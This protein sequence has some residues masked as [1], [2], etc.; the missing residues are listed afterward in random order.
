MMQAKK[1]IAIIGGSGLDRLNDMLQVQEFSTETPFGHHSGPI[2][3][4]TLNQIDCLFIPR[5]HATRRTPPHKINYRANIWALK[6]LSITDIIAINVVGGISECMSPETLVLPDQLIDYTHGREQSYY[7]ER[8]E[9][10]CDEIKQFEQHIDFSYPYSPKLRKSL[11]QQLS[12]ASINFQSKATYGC[13]QGPRLETVAEIK[14]LKQDG[15]DIVGMTGMPE[16]SLAK[17]L[18]INYV[19]ICVVANWAAGTHPATLSYEEVALTIKRSMTKVES[20]LPEMIAA[21]YQG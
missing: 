12:S 11:Q 8:I 15:C 10:S 17:E 3:L 4:G 14:R 7:D 18:G 21:I 20:L 9:Q 19:S 5:H 1:R 6:K 16:A 2:I 13:T